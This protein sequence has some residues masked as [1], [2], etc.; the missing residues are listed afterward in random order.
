MVKAALK[1]SPKLG[2]QVTCDWS[3]TGEA[4]QR[5]QEGQSN[6]SPAIL[7]TP[8]R[9]SYVNYRPDRY[10]CRRARNR[11]GQRPDYYCDDTAVT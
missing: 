8:R 3:V 6:P 7:L 2:L 10:G 1:A 5:K 9:N 4:R 11:I